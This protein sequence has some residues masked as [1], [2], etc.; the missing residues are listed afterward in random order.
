MAKSNPLFVDSTKFQG[1]LI[2]THIELKDVLI[3]EEEMLSVIVTNHQGIT[4]TMEM[5][6]VEGRSFEARIHLNHQ[7]AFTYQFVIEKGG[8]RVYQS[9]IFEGRASYSVMQKWNPVLEDPAKDLPQAVE[10][11]MANPEDEEV[12]P[13]L[14][15]ARESS[16]EVKSLIDKWGF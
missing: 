6:V 2:V 16:K 14:A 3:Y 12:D 5:S 15:W 13:S 4:R 11:E 7:T 8:A 1:D 10:P 9:L